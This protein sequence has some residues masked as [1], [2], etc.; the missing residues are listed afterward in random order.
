MAQVRGSGLK[1]TVEIVSLKPCHVSVVEG[2]HNSPLF[3]LMA[4]L[5][6]HVR[7][8]LR[9]PT[10]CEV[11]E[12]YIT[13]EYTEELAVAHIRRLLDIV[14]CTTTFGA[15]PPRHAGGTAALSSGS[16]GKGDT[17]PSDTAKAA[18]TISEAPKTEATAG[19]PNTKAGSKKPD[20]PTSAVAGA[21]SYKDE[22]LYP[23]PKLAQF[24]DFFSFSHLTPPLQY[25]PSVFPPLP[26]EDETWGG[27]GGGQGRD[28]KHDQRP[29]A[30]EF[31]ILAAM[32]CKT[33]EERQI[34]DR[35]AFLLH[36]LFV[37][38]AVVK[39]VEAIQHLD[40]ATL[41]VVVIRHCG[42]TVVVKVPV[43]AGLE[44][45]LLSTFSLRALL[46][47]STSSCGAQKSQCAD[48]ED[49]QSFRSLVREVLA[50]SLQ[51]LQEEAT[52]QRMSIRWELGACWVQHLQNQS[53]GKTE[54]KKSEDSKVETTVKGL[55]KQ[56]GQLKQI[57][58]K[59]DDKGWKTDSAKE[60]SCVGM[61]VDGASPREDK[62][63]ALQKLLPEAAYLRLK[64][65]ETGLHVKVELSDKLPHVQSLCIHEM[66]V[67]AYKH[68]L[69]AI[70][71]AVGDITD[72]AG[73]IASCLNILLGS[74]P[75][76]NADFNLDNDYHLK[77][78]WLESFL[79]KRF[80]WRLKNKDCHD[81]R[82]YAIL[83]GLCHK[84]L[85]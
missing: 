52:E 35:K 4:S 32:P 50:D 5:E 63:M 47:K 31:T 44:L 2:T 21:A 80:G 62:E 72:M 57:K 48:L 67:R 81:L 82:K 77:Q 45:T 39:A 75:A 56:F 22:P 16:I 34:R 26:T 71:A 13:E 51:R 61:D 29:W 74:L 20:S 66:I 79:L 43:E 38:V 65:S 85:D 40:T 54:S 37:D 55:G 73:T 84:V 6:A 1:D 70:I 25:S 58:K 78:K 69:Q 9:R 49:L 27:N 24:Y 64:E 10:Y 11:F 19:S 18:E 59:L 14:A 76:D 23:P 8:I 42:Y 15:A 68:I 46:H 7:I 41:S 53:S 30:N 36:S 33:P 17:K 12:H 28:G 60:N 3:A 83:R